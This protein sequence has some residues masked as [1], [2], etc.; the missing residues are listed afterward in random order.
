M[1]LIINDMQDKNNQTQNNI[2]CQQMLVDDEA[3]DTSEERIESVEDMEVLA[4][5]SSISGQFPVKMR[6]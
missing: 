5:R 6:I 3:N 4:Q 1:P 2:F